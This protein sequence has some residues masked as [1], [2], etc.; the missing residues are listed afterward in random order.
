MKA[1]NQNSKTPK[2]FYVH[3]L[4]PMVFYSPLCKRLLT[5]TQHLSCFIEIVWGTSLW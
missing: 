1:F 2:P 3:D 4:F 5:I